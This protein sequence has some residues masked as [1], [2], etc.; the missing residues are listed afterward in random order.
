LYP[1]EI[2]KRAA[3]LKSDVAAF[4]LLD[5]IPSVKRGTGGMVCLYDNLATLDENDRT[6]PVN[7]L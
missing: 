7:M 6:I 5:K 4:R 3:P 2:K 1:I